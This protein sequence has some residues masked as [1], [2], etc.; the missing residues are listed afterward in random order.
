MVTDIYAW[1]SSLSLKHNSSLFSI[2]FVSF[3]NRCFV[4]EIGRKMVV[5]TSSGSIRTYFLRRKSLDPHPRS[6][7]VMWE[8][9][10]TKTPAAHSWRPTPDRAGAQSELMRQGLCKAYYIHPADAL[11]LV[12]FKRSVLVL[13]LIKRN[14]DRRYGS[15]FHRRQIWRHALHARKGQSI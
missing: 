6:G 13:K 15:W 5:T 4:A 1:I 2:K 9:N 12:D 8:L 14:L 7:W 3:S 11:A 10:H